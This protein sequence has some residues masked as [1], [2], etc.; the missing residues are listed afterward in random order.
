MLPNNRLFHILFQK[1]YFKQL[2]AYPYKLRRIQIQK[3]SLKKINY[4]LVIYT[5]N[6]ITPKLT[7]KGELENNMQIGNEIRMSL[8][9]RQNII[10]LQI[11]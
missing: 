10:K 4:N 8:D 5:Q 3:E 1:V 7:V 6:N 2:L 9:S 11:K